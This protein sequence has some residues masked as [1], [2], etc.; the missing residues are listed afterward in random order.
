LQEKSGQV[1]RYFSSGMKQR[2]KLLLA[3]LSDTTILLLDEPCS[4]LDSNGIEWFQKMMADY[5]GNR[6]VIIASNHNEAEYSF[7]D[8]RMNMSSFKV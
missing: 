3:I 4:N 1:F 6:I 5:A 7:C 8:S 2:I